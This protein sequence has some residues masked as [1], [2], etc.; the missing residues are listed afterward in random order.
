MN[1]TMIPKMITIPEAAKESGLPLHFLRQLCLNRK[2]KIVKAGKKYLI[3]RDS[4]IQYLTE[5]DETDEDS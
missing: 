2:V 4:L 3:N 5:G 1:N